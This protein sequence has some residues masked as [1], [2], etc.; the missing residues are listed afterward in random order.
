MAIP[1]R[2]ALVATGAFAL[3]APHVAGAQ[4]DGL[5]ALPDVYRVQSENSWV[6]VVRVRISG[7]ADLPYHTHPPG[8]MLHVYLD[9]ANPIVFEHDGSPNTVTRPYVAAR[10]YR[11]GR[12][13]PE[14]RAVVNR[15]PGASEYLR[16]ELK[17]AGETRMGQR[18]PAPPLAN[19][20][21]A[22]VEVANLQYR[23]T[24]I[25]IA[26][27]DSVVVSPDSGQPAIVIALTTGVRTSSGLSL[28]LG[29]DV[30]T[31][32][33]QRLVLRNPG[34][35]PA[36]LL[37]VD[38]LTEPAVRPGPPAMFRGGPDHSGVYDSPAPALQSVAWTGTCSR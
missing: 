30:F 7:N 37:R 15:F 6:R 25:T 11:V 13:T 32:S 35:G 34:S 27:A 24:R 2:W 17:T 18:V 21:R 5:V 19:A 1:I 22:V 31:E 3:L 33:G 8:V 26:A 28:P 12:A 10:S 36:E 4:Q 23:T 38:L 20:T 29:Q 14:S 9:D 16:V